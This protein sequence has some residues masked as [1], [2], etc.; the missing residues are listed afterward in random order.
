MTANTAATRKA[1]GRKLEKAVAKHYRDHKIDESAQPMPLSGAMA[2]FKGDIHKRNDWEWI[3]EC[4]KHETIKL[5][6]FW[7]QAVEQTSGL[8][9][10]AFQ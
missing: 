4:K 8:V 2:H 7:D 3:D 9:C 5:G 10:V 1:K 6:E